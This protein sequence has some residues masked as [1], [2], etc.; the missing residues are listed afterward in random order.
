MRATFFS[1]IEKYYK[2]DKKVF[3]LTADLGFKLFDKIKSVSSKRFY[4]V[5]IAEANMVGLASGIALSGG[6]VYCYS[7][8]P[9]LIMRAYE[10]IRVDIDYHD[11]D[12][13][14]VGMGSGFSYG[15]E[16]ITHFGL[17][18]IALMRSLKN[19][20]VTVPADMHEAAAF[21]EISYKHKGPMFI[22]IGRTNAP[23]VYSKRPKIKLGKAVILKEG[24][25]VAIFAT[26]DMVYN[27]LQSADILKKRGIEASVINVH[28][29]KPLDKKAIKYAAE[30]HEAIFSVEEHNI[31]GG[32]GSAVA[33][34]M[35]EEGMNCLF[36]RI[37]I[38]EKL[39]NVMGKADYLRKAYGLHPE[40]I[41]DTIMKVMGKVNR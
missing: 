35:A 41:A 33:E 10:Q 4:N 1:T 22:R 13:K 29:I 38:P 20:A 12:V 37:A 24:K 3:V 5:G 23:F 32:L 19:M 2:K 34:V 28:T 18:D 15:L 9:F 31:T 36:R 14:L 26:G 21:A 6:K 17:E 30:R 8:I 11:L 25:H 39:K 7:I 16:G 27:S 40:G